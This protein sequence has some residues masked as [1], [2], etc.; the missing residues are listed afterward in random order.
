LV[1]FHK[2]YAGYGLVYVSYKGSLYILGK[3]FSRVDEIIDTEPNVSNNT[4]VLP[5]DNDGVITKHD[6]ETC[7]EVVNII[8][9]R[10][11]NGGIV[12]GGITALSKAWKHFQKFGDKLVSSI[13]TPI[14]NALGYILLKFPELKSVYYPLKGVKI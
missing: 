9:V 11:G 5:N 3:L 1:K 7:K 10:G 2:I 13:I 12:V 4:N 8:S 14:S 6:Y